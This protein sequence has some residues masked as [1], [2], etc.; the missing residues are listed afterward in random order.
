MP[1]QGLEEVAESAGIGLVGLTD[2][3]EFRLGLGIL[4][5]IGAAS[6]PTFRTL[7]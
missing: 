6:R 4:A 2:V 1:E 3:L 7:E 5:D